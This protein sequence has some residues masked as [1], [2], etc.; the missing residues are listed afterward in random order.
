MAI[1]GMRKPQ[2][3]NFQPETFSLFSPSVEKFN[4][5]IPSAL[6]ILCRNHHLGNK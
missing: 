1:T 6:K 3:S 4:D 2:T 5:S